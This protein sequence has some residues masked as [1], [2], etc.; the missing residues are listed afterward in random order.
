MPGTQSED[1]V[2]QLVPILWVS[3]DQLFG[4][5]LEE[6]RAAFLLRIVS[7]LGKQ[8]DTQDWQD[9]QTQSPAMQR[10]GPGQ[11]D[12]WKIS[13]TGWEPETLLPRILVWSMKEMVA[14]AGAAKGKKMTLARTHLSRKPPKPWHLRST[15]LLPREV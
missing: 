3:F 13:L 7:S 4:K 12:T 11:G 2:A 14:A 8:S 9:C 5:P 6:N 10:C 15:F 1:F